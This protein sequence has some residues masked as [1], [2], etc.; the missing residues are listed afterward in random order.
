MLSVAVTNDLCALRSDGGTRTPYHL[1]GSGE[2][3]A[4][5]GAVE[6]DEFFEG[7]P[8]SGSPGVEGVS[9]RSSAVSPD[10]GFKA[11]SELSAFSLETAVSDLG[12]SSSVS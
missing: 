9:V 11:D 8:S 5:F 4:L 6:L 2:G 7:A 3:K 10:P 12:F 1:R